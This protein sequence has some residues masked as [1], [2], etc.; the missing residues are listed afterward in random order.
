MPA[1]VPEVTR[2]ALR[3]RRSFVVKD[4]A[5]TSNSFSSNLLLNMFLA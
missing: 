4:E 3:Q 1:R 5:R 2:C